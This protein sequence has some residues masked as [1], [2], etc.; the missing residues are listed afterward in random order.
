M[1]IFNY[2]IIYFY[3]LMFNIFYNKKNI[4]KIYK[5]NMFYN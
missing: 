2:Y 3:N 4:I 1:L 5:N